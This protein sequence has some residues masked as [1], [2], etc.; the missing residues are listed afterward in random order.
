MNA[1]YR[2]RTACWRK[3]NR[4]QLKQAVAWRKY[5]GYGRGA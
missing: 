4:F 1:I 5:A 2:W 3:L